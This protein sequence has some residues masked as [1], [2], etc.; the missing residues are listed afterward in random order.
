MIKSF[1]SFSCNRPHEIVVKY[2]KHSLVQFGTTH[3]FSFTKEGQ[4]L[5]GTSSGV[6][7]LILY[8]EICVHM[9]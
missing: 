3:Y 4:R 2:K 8:K 1:S 5:N 9:L 6:K 7:V